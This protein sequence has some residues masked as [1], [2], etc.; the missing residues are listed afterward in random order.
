MPIAGHSILAIEVA[1]YFANFFAMETRKNTHTFKSEDEFFF[2]S[3]YR[4]PPYYMHYP[5]EQVYFFI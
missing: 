4:H 5:Y 3:I 1:Q 2:S